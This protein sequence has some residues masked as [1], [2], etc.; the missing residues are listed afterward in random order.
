MTGDFRFGDFRW[1]RQ[2]GSPIGD[3][4]GATGA[5]LGTG[6]GLHDLFVEPARDK[7]PQTPAKTGEK[8]VGE[9]SP[10]G[11]HLQLQHLVGASDGCP[12]QDSNLRHTV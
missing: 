3:G 8:Q 5:A 6:L 1:R 12:Q 4:T 7:Q 11:T 10:S 9:H 2:F